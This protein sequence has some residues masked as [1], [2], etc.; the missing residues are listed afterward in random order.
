MLTPGQMF[1]CTE[2]CDTTIYLGQS[3]SICRHVEMPTTYIFIPSVSFEQSVCCVSQLVKEA[4]SHHNQLS[5][6]VQKEKQSRQEKEEKEN[7]ERAS[8]LEEEKTK[9]QTQEEPRIKELTDEEAERLQSELNQVRANLN[10]HNY[11]H[12]SIIY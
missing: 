10:R 5:L 9:K 3:V 6:K 12:F 2:C 4:F 7:A 11:C 1:R 8:K